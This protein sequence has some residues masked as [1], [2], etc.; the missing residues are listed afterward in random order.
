MLVGHWEL[1]AWKPGWGILV[2]ALLSASRQFVTCIMEGL[3]GL[4]I[5]DADVGGSLLCILD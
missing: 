1:V 4:D 3:L 2:S 5:E